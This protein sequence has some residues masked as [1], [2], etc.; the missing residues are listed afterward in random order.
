MARVEEKEKAD[1]IYA[2]AIKSNS[3][4]GLVQQVLEQIFL[5]HNLRKIYAILRNIIFATNYLTFDM[6]DLK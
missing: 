4:A 3:A 1:D 6:S 5:C 2:N